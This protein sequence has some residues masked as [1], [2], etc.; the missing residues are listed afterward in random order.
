[1]ANNLLYLGKTCCRPPNSCTILNCDGEFALDS[2]TIN[3]SGSLVSRSGNG[4]ADCWNGTTLVF[5]RTYDRDWFEANPSPC[6]IN[7][8]ANYGCCTSVTRNWTFVDERIIRHPISTADGDGPYT[9]SGYGTEQFWRRP[10]TY[11]ERKG[12]FILAEYCRMFFNASFSANRMSIF[13][14]LRWDMFFYYYSCKD[15]Y[16]M[17]NSRATGNE[18]LF[19]CDMTTCDTPPGIT[20]TDE[21]P[22]A[23]SISSPSCPPRTYPAANFIGPSYTT[24]SLIRNYTGSRDLVGCD[25]IC[26]PLTLTALSVN[27]QG[28]KPGTW[29]GSGIRTFT[30]SIPKNDSTGYAISYPLPTQWFYWSPTT[31]TTVEDPFPFY[32]P[33]YKTPN[34]GFLGCNLESYAIQEPCYDPSPSITISLCPPPIVDP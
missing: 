5:P 24:A 13:L 17:P 10:H 33:I 30:T 34:D 20:C 9:L 31:G 6:A 1:M 29:S 15:D 4:C 2:V 11:M 12:T 27:T 23:S 21:F 16:P 19:T 25:D 26:D 8:S 22:V 3:A 32:N 14:T 28:D 18:N 7:S